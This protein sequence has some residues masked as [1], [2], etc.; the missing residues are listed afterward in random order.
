[1][2]PAPPPSYT[3]VDPPSI[4]VPARATEAPPAYSFPER[5]TI[6][7]GRTTE[8]FVNASQLKDHLALL[9]AF[10]ELKLSAE[11]MG[12]D[13]GIPHLP[14]EKEERWVFFVGLAVERFEKWCRALQPSHS[15]KGLATILP[16]IDVIMVWHAYLLNPGWYAEDGKRI[17]AFKGLLQAGEA[18][19]A[20]LGGELGELLAAEPSQRRIDNWVQ[21]TAT[22]FDPFKAATEMVTR[23]IACPKCRSVVYA[24]YMTAEATGYL[25]QNFTIKCT[26]TECNFDIT[27][28]TLALRKLVKDL[29]RTDASGKKA[30]DMLAGTIHTATNVQDLTRGRIVKGTMLSSFT[31]KR[32]AGQT[33]GKLMSDFAYGD[34]L[35][36]LGQYQLP[37]LRSQLTLKMKAGGGKLM[38]RIMSAYV[39]DK[40]F[41]VELVGAV[42]RQ[43]S[44]VTKMYDL[45]WT[46]PGFFDSTEDEVALQHSIARYHAFLDLMSSSPA[47][48]FVPTLDID[49]AW[50]TH[51]LMASNYTRDTVGFVGRFIDHDDKVEESQLASSFDITCRAWKNRFGVQYTHCGCPLPGQTIGQRLSRLVGQ[52]TNPSYLI[53]PNR[54]TLLAATHP[55]DHNAVF[56]FHHKAAS[57][58][59]QRRRRE[60]IAKRAQRELKEGKAGG[61]RGLAHDPAFLVPVPMYYAAGFAGLGAGNIVNGGIG[62]FGGCAVGAGACGVG[63]AACG[64]TGCGGG[65]CEFP[66]FCIP[67]PS[68]YSNGL[69]SRGCWRRV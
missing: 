5:F 68:L 37:K 28:D 26:K 44:F 21:M 66:H 43:G 49:L 55:S 4:D 64:A 61:R 52:T 32:P 62:G 40:M 1:M 46:R 38:G 58:A 53:P 24:P 12:T 67:Y 27:R 31:L 30:T 65:G 17:E 8:P 41:S 36:Q 23:D 34:L 51:Q 15:E 3:S 22:S 48:F 13:L 54:D 2:E 57:E 7:S 47:S 9:H 10:A 56:A 14:T 19:G 29:A 60:K 39:D 16:P 59:A 6:G 45:Q 25:Q 33:P 50:H 11:A 63:G 35:M 69:S 20:A 18:F 42:L